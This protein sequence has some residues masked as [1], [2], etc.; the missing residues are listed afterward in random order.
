MA[1]VAGQVHQLLGIGVQLRLQPA[2]DR[3]SILAGSARTL[4]SGLR[5]SGGVS[6]CTVQLFQSN[7]KYGKCSAL[8]LHNCGALVC[9]SSLL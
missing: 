8:G 2:Q 9:G 1:V 6:K 3:K 5:G 4:R 7:C